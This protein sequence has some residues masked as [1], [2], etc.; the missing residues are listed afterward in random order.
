MGAT[1]IVSD[2]LCGKLMAIQAGV[3]TKSFGKLS[4]SLCWKA[5]PQSF[6]EKYTIH[7]LAI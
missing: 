4:H 3:P 5:F 6:S 7:N 2:K 1:Y